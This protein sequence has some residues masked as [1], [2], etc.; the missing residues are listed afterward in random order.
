MK[1]KVSVI[2]PIYNVSDYIEKCMDSLV[3]Q[4]L[5]ELQIIL[6]NDGSTDDSYEKLIPY[7][8]KYKN[9]EYYEKENGGLSD[10][11]NYGFKYVSSPYVA[12]LDSDDYIK[13]SMYEDL[14]NKCVKED[15][16][17]CECDFYWTYDDKK[18]LD[19]RIYNDENLFTNLRVVAWNKLYKYSVIKEHN[20]E[21][22]KNLRYEDIGFIY[23]LLPYIKKYGYL[24]K[25]C[26]YY[27]QR[28]TSITAVQ[29]IKVLDI[30]EIFNGIFKFYKEQNIYEKY[31]NELEYVYIR[32]MFSSSF[33]R[34]CKIGDKELKNKVLKEN[35][36]NIKTTFPNY[37]KNKYIKGLKPRNLYY[38]FMNYP[39][40]KI[41]SM[42]VR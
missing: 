4:T 22:L 27:I 39:M 8:N 37:K 34:M 24:D 18:I 2:V 5:K 38:R 26:V 7:I 41:M 11:R 29:N 21:F 19:K 13:H 33:K 15:L 3:N 6:I 17:I 1:Y 20:I 12:F 32:I 31:K 9:I 10:A 28:N 14:Y 35:Y 23:M 42:L 16:D 30:N 25:P 36:K 40:Y